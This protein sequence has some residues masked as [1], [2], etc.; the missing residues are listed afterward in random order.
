MET[1]PFTKEGFEELTKELDELKRIER[2]K[3]IHQIAEARDFG[4]LKENAEY[5]TA[6]E[7]QVFIEARIRDLDDK[8]SRAQIVD[9]SNETPHIVKFGAWV[10]VSDEDSGETRCLRI[11]GDPES[12][13]EHHKISAH[14]PIAQ[15]MLGKKVDDTVVVRLPKG[16]KEYVVMAIAYTPPQS[17]NN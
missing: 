16:T 7:K 5:H 9:F 4:D 2:P 3:I 15:A 13:V 14:S 10:T 1:I 12:D 6:R 17:H 8:L 11:V